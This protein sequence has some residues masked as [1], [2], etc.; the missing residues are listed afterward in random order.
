MSSLRVELTAPGPLER[1]VIVGSDEVFGWW[2]P[3]KGAALDWTGEAWETTEPIDLDEG[4]Q[5][6]DYKFVRVADRG[7]ARWEDGRNRVLEVPSAGPREMMLVA[8]FNGSA[9]SRPWTPSEDDRTRWAEVLGCAASHCKAKHRALTR[10]LVDW[11]TTAGRERQQWTMEESEAKAEEEALRSE[12]AVAN[13]ELERARGALAAVA[14]AAALAAARPC[15]P[16]LH[17]GADAGSAASSVASESQAPP[18]S[19]SPQDAASSARSTYEGGDDSDG[20]DAEG[21]DDADCD[22]FVEVPAMVAATGPNVVAKFC[23]SG[24]N[25]G[26]PPSIALG[27]A[28]DI[29]IAEDPPCRSRLQWPVFPQLPLP[30]RGETTVSCRAR[31]PKV[32]LGGRNVSRFK[33]GLAGVGFQGARGNGRFRKGYSPA[34]WPQKWGGRLAARGTDAK[35]GDEAFERLIRNRHMDTGGGGGGLARSQQLLD[36]SFLTAQPRP[37]KA[38]PTD[39]SSGGDKPKPTTNS[40]GVGGASGSA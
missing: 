13:A 40:I 9:M 10:E 22:A 20:S 19:T 29:A 32:H 14:A 11:R 34:P 8:H 17:A 4:C 35:Q 21:V 24:A 18:P 25:I 7:V 1:V 36:A 12:L 33:P 15:S 2:D 16:M 27:A 39:P 31:S 30:T 37:E 5:S 3:S 26:V 38:I 28:Y 23:T 6:I